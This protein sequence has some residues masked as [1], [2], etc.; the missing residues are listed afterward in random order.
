MTRRAGG[1]A[2]AREPRS[3]LAW[4]QA[5][6]RLGPGVH[7]QLQDHVVHGGSGLEPVPVDPG[8]DRADHRG[9]LRDSRMRNGGEGPDG[10]RGHDLVV[11]RAL[12]RVAP[13]CPALITSPGLLS[14]LIE[15]MIQYVFRVR[16]GPAV[17]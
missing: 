9:S 15:A 17:G 12:L 6:Q 11:W 4:Q 2:R 10:M 14:G 7:R 13:L 16:R 1:P 8:N 3:L 5:L